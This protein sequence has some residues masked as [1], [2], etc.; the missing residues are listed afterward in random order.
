[1]ST[2]NTNEVNDINTDEIKQQTVC[3]WIN[4]GRCFSFQLNTKIRNFLRGVYFMHFDKMQT[5]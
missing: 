5:K 2:Q 4:F 1:M 3:Y